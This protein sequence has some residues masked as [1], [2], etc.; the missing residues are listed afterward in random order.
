MKTFLLEKTFGAKVILSELL[1]LDIKKQ[2]GL[3]LASEFMI[4]NRR[5]Q[6]KY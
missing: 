3:K 1:R 4:K 6:R 2:I 5:T